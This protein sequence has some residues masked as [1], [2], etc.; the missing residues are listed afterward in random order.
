[1]FSRWFR[2]Y[3]GESCYEQSICARI[4]GSTFVTLPYKALL[5]RIVLGEGK[6]EIQKLGTDQ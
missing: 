3:D 1:M 2:V 6:K 4:S 5:G